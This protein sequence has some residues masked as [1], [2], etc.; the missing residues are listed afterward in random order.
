MARSPAP[1]FARK[2][3]AKT[4]ALKTRWQGHPLQALVKPIVAKT[5]ALKTRWQGHPLQA[6][7]KVNRQ[8][9]SFADS[10]AR[11]PAPGFGWN[12]KPK[13]KLWR[14][15]GKVTS[16]RLWL[17]QIAK[18]QALEDSMARSPAQLGRTHSQNSSF[19]DSMA[20]SSAPVLG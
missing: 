2:P 9:S 10:R 11:S 18:T 14:L 6:L 4:Q 12:L 20:S 13:L 1:G 17:K 16:S 3:P 8:N 5:Q 15:D 19:E 7:V